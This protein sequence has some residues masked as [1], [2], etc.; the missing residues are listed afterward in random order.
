[1]PTNVQ[2]K[3]CIARERGALVFWSPDAAQR[4]PGARMQILDVFSLQVATGYTRD[5]QGRLLLE[6]QPS[7]AAGR[8]WSLA[9]AAQLIRNDVR[10]HR[11]VALQQDRRAWGLFWA[12]GGLQHCRELLAAQASGAEPS[13]ALKSSA[14]VPVT[15]EALL[16]VLLDLEA[17]QP[18]AGRG[19]SAPRSWRPGRAANPWKLVAGTSLAWM[20]VLGITVAGFLAVLERQDRQLELLLERSAPASQA[21]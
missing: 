6:A 3:R 7:L 4:R 20:V 9:K 10:P 21:P 19:S 14:L 1:M 16:R 13:S 8:S 2:M 12:G 11:W 17:E 5:P 18:G 15:P